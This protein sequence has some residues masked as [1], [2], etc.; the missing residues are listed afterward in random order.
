MK[1][2]VIARLSAMNGQS[3]AE[4]SSVWDYVSRSPLGSL[5]NLQGVPVLIVLKRTWR[6]LLA[7]NLLGRAAELAFFFLFALFP[8][9]FSASSILG[10]AARSA[11][12]IY[13]KLLEYLALVVPTS[14]LGMV[15][16]TFNETTANAT[17][18]KLTFGL[19][20]AIWSASVGVS[21]IQDSLN[22]IYNVQD[23]RSYFQARFA[24]I[25]VTVILVVLGT[26]TLASL[27]G[28]DFFAAVAHTNLTNRFAAALFAF[29]SRVIFW[30]TATGLLTLCF[31]V[32]Y[33]W[34]PGVKRRRWRWLT[35][36]SA[37]GILAWVLVSLGF[38]LYLHY[39]NFYSITYG[40][41]GA[42]IILLMWF[43]ITGFMLLLGAE[44]NSEIEAAAAERNLWGLTPEQISTTTDITSA[45]PQPAEPPSSSEPTTDRSASPSETPSRAE[46][47]PSDPPV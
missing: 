35:P 31:A 47:E 11:S 10:L 20:A 14:A 29:C 22:T 45:E 28:G 7:D 24:A 15:L 42:V 27:L 4:Q 46:E 18:G 41:L 32:I 34:A 37:V 26:L 36:G 13:Y 6:S 39:F 17:S 3:Q 25:G 43:Y 1:G 2:L 9:L 40:S 5:W 30:T 23:Q 19:I 8:T 44:I 16:T 12:S 38:R 33:Y 21:A